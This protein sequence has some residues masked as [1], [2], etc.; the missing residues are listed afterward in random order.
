M[1]QAVT[2]NFQIQENTGRRATP[3][4]SSQATAPTPRP[5]V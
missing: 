4:L 5:A 3:K 2:I 1:P